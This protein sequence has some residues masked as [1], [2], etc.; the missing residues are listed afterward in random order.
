MDMDSVFVYDLAVVFIRFMDF[1]QSR[2]LE[3][4]AEQ[5]FIQN[6][7]NCIYEFFKSSQVLLL[8]H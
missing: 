5:L 3:N 2:S 6:E 8:A 7:M 1:A 4:R